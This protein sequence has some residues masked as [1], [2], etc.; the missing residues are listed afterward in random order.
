MSSQYRKRR[1]LQITKVDGQTE[2]RLVAQA[3]MSPEI[4]NTAAAVDWSLPMFPDLS[5]QECVELLR[6]EAANVRSGD[7][8]TMEATLVAQVR[9]LDVIFTSLAAKAA[10]S[11]TPA[12]VESCLR[13][14]FKAQ[15]QSRATVEALHEM[16]HPKLATFI[17]QQ[18]IAQQQ[19][20]NNAAGLPSRA[21]D[22]Q[23]TRNELLEADNGKRLDT[24]APEA[25]SRADQ[26]LEAVGKIDRPKNRRRQS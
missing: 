7:M 16:K 12:Q 23:Q 26:S 9:T 20:V 15:S 6:A 4:G 17:G 19:Q 24:R 22:F 18:N 14:A 5:M 21:Q 8:S 11:A 10:L 3:A 13:L 25:P 2:D 1:T